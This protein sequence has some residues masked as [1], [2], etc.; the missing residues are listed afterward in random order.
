MKKA[1]SLI[2]SIALCICLCAC[3]KSEAVRS[4]EDAISAIGEVSADSGE[5]IA[6][7]EK[8][9]GILTDAEREKVENRLA[10]VEAREQFDKVIGEIVYTNAKE[11]YEKLKEVADLCISGMDDIYNAWYFGI[12]KAE[13][14]LPSRFYDY[15]AYMAQEVPSFSADDLKAAAE[16]LGYSEAM[17]KKDW[18]KSLWIVE[19]AIAKRGD[20]DTI[21]ANMNEAEKV[22]QA[23]TEEYNDYTYYPKLK[24]YYAAVKSY[25]EF[26][27]SPSGSFKQLSDTINNY[28]NG[29]RTLESDVSFLFSK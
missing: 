7:A 29:I 24:D 20:Y 6:N 11:A 5:A 19:S 12:Y 2:M 9:Y 4:A 22:L 8:Y 16:S 13:D 23:L 25:V 3:G 26:Y 28:E 17:V 27:T 15:Y 10:L 21:A 18:Q 1:I 14:A